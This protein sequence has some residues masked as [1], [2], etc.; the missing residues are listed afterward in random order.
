MPA[1]EPGG[2]RHIKKSWV[3][4]PALGF[5]PTAEMRSQEFQR[6]VRDIKMHGV[7]YAGASAVEHL[8]P[9]AGRPRPLSPK[10][11]QIFRAELQSTMDMLS[12]AR[13]GEAR[14]QRQQAAAHMAAEASAARH[15]LPSGTV[16]PRCAPRLMCLCAVHPCVPG[17]A[18]SL[19]ACAAPGRDLRRCRHLASLAS[20]SAAPRPG[21]RCLL[22]H[23]SLVPL[24][25]D[26]L[27]PPSRGRGRWRR[28]WA[29]LLGAAAGA[30][31]L[32]PR[33]ALQP[34]RCNP[35]RARVG[36]GSVAPR[37]AP[38]RPAAAAAAAAAE[39]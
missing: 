39:A 6:C 13:V 24:G 2:P 1:G 10:N 19:N 26:G 36:G 21:W 17:V 33:A 29:V 15:Q 23:P 30:P 4:D 27:D 8:P 38:R 18:L 34:R 12:S 7:S 31:E 25:A 20:P 3:P 28:R 22:L 16:R 32:T 14:A 5:E 35:G 9:G 11:R 37:R